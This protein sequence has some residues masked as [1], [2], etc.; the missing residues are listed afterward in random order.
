MVKKFC[1]RKPA[2]G[3]RPKPNTE[4]HLKF[5]SDLFFH[6]CVPSDFALL[7]FFLPDYFVL[8]YLFHPCFMSCLPS[9]SAHGKV[10]GWASAFANLA[11]DL[12]LR[13]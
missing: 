4:K 6:E 13:Y 5:Y 2:I 9:F 12:N 1:L 10:S 3:P 8:L 11:A 7:P